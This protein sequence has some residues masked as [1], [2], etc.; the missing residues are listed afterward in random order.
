M[1]VK[2]EKTDDTLRVEIEGSVDAV[3]S[4]ELERE[5]LPELS[6]VN[7]IIF[8]MKDMDYIS[9]AGLRV[10]LKIYQIISV[11][12]SVIVLENV[13]DEFKYIFMDSGF[14]KFMEIR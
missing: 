3:T 14:A 11:K 13:R 9:S 6:D 8:N 2:K 12:K 4:P 10:L 5:L 1:T 7:S